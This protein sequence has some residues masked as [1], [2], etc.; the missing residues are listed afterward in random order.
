MKKYTIATIGSHSALQILKG[1]RDE[2]FAT[3]LFSK[4]DRIDFYKSFNFIDKIK[5]VESFSEISE[6]EDK[7][8]K[9]MIIIPHGSFVAYLGVK[10]NKNISMPY[11]GNKEVL[12]WEGNRVKQRLWL[13]KAGLLLPKQFKIG[14]KDLKYPVIVKTDGAAGGEGYF[15]AKDVKELQKRVRKLKKKYIIQ[16]Y[17]IGVPM[18]FHYFYSSINKK[19]EIL[20]IDRRYETNADALGR[21]PLNFHRLKKIKPSFVVVGNSPLVVRESLLPKIYSMG[22]KVVKTSRNLID[23]RG[24]FG[25]F[26]L[27]TI[28]TPDQKIYIIEISARIVAGTNLY[29]NGSSYASY[30]YDE[31]M[32]TG[33]RIAQEIKL[34]I[35]KGKIRDVTS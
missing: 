32:S 27:E 15:F 18:Y 19:L 3:L 33:R 22:K 28:I 2:G 24:L 16:K 5:E 11:F 34:A 21:L 1:A 7:L 23:K 30:Y 31:P 9:D 13:E 6:R 20:S 4:R 17:I 10:G 14:D 29:I 12:D 25:P 35:N 8:N 26:C